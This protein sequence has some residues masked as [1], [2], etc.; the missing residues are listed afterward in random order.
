MM[1]LE[2]YLSRDITS[3]QWKVNPALFH[4]PLHT[5]PAA[6]VDLYN[7]TV[8]VTVIS[9]QSMLIHASLILQATYGP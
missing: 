7:A 8:P 2:C 5:I 1:S 6:L 9:C 4:S 3:F